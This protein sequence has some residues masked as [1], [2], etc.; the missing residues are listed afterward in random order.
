MTSL[1][2]RSLTVEE[3]D[4]ILSDVDQHLPQFL[5]KDLSEGYIKKIVIPLRNQLLKVQVVD[6][7]DI[8]PRL[9]QSIHDSIQRSIVQ[10]GEGVGVICAQSI[11][12]RQTQLTLNSFHSSGLSVATVVT[13]VPRFLELLNATKDPKMSSNRFELSVQGANT[14][15]KMRQ[16]LQHHIVH[17]SFHDLVVRDTIHQDKEE[18]VWYG[19]FE[20]VYS[21]QFRDYHACLSFELD[22]KKMHQYKITPMKICEKL[23]AQF[24]DICCVF[25]PLHIGQLDVFVDITQVALPEG[26]AVPAFLTAQN[27]IH[28][29]LEDIVKVKL[30]E[31]KICG[32]TGVQ[33]YH[34]LKNP[35]SVFHVETEGSNLEGLV[36][37]P[38][39]D[40]ASVRSNNMWDIYQV[41]GIEATREFLL[42]EFTNIVSSDGTF[43]NPVHILLLVDIMTHHGTINSVS[44]YGLK[45]EQVGVLSRSSFEESLDHF[46]NA[47]FYAEKEPVKAVSAAIMC[48]KRSKIGSGLCS[49][50]MDWKMIHEQHDQKKE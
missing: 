31:V 48:G 8:L 15:Q 38:F 25:S 13:G 33:N 37:L 11:G 29:F 27:Y 39:V 4:A 5:P 7:P 18:E 17:V 50:L 22:L 19:A 14:P 28:V 9:R 16:V 47:G 41:M 34:I 30:F 1:S 3:I 42:E 24:A 36:A 2:K 21:N 23:E 6:H 12:E 43:L 49:L 20:T 26:P 32:L 45:K 44:R 46:C 35:E 10:A 40:I